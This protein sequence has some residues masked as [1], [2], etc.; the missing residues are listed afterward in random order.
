M[1]KIFLYALVAALASCSAFIIHVL[2][3][4]WLPSWISQQMSGRNITPSWDVRYVAALTSIEYG[5]GA[6]LLY[7]AARQTLM[8]HIVFY[9]AVFLS[10]CLAMVSG[11]L[12][13]QPLMDV[14]VGNPLHVTMVQN[15]FKWLVWM[16]LGFIVV[17][18]VEAVKK[19]LKKGQSK[20]VPLS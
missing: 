5:I 17:Y 10:V 12:I 19:V 16:L 8:R 2:T 3:V 7:L 1:K 20:A 9:R 6:V 18:G 15:L 4:E 11:A 14:V 13:R